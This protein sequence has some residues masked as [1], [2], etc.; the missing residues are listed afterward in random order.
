MTDAGNSPNAFTVDLEDWFQGLTSTNPQ[1]DQWPLF[2]S[3]VVPAT[4]RLLALLRMYRIQATF[5]VLG[6]IA[7]C[8]PTLVDAIQTDGHEIAVHGYWHS[9][10]SRLTPHQFSLEIERSVK[11]IM[12]I[13][14]QMPVGH[15]APYFSVNRATPWVFD[16]LQEHGFLYDSSIFP[17]RNGYYGY[18]GAP[19]FPYTATGA[20]LVE[21]PLS[22]VRLAGVNWPVA[23]GFYL[24][25][26]PHAFIRWAIRQLNR[27]GQPAVLYLHPW[28]LDLDQP[29]HSV[30][31][32]ERITHYAGRR[33]LAAKLHRL[34]SEFCFVPLRT[35]LEQ[36]RHSSPE[37]GYH[38][39]H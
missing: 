16:V 29:R 23:G 33:R 27:Q 34:F 39:H 13:T 30:T 26:W 35:L 14:G 21:F 6:H 17:I 9:Y 1:V 38:D 8:H 7:D 24:R 18:P 11:A 19:R 32:R 15:R 28:E 3:R 12:R 2:E 5:F 31:P 25:M 22:T 37:S 36:T 4:L 20:G 10:V